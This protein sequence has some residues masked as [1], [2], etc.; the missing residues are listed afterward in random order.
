MDKKTISIVIVAIAC[1]AVVGFG[2][3]RFVFAS[4]DDTEKK[5]SAETSET[6]KKEDDTVDSD[7]TEEVATDGTIT[8][9]LTYP[10]EGIPPDMEIHA[11]NTVTEHDYFVRDHL[12]GEEYAYGVG[13]RMDVPAGTYYVYGVLPSNPDQKAYYNEFVRCGMSVD[14]TDMTK[15]VVTV[16]AGKETKGVV[17]GDWYNL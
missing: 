17:V 8:G 12:S 2:V 15:V 16:E 4:S 5:S 9:S 7:T 14:C 13:F 11:Y 6:V 10:S 1:I 3:W